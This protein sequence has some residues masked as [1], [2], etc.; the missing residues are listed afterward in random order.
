MRA[1]EQRQ[2]LGPKKDFEKSAGEETSTLGPTCFGAQAAVKIWTVCAPQATAPGRSVS[3][4]A[5]LFSVS[6]RQSSGGR[7]G[8]QQ[9]GQL[10]ARQS[11]S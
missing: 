9:Q 11:L 7:A 8:G 6:S 10:L 5:S 2:P 3:R 4:R 1:K